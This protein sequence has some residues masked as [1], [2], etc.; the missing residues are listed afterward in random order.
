MA[1]CI[2]RIY[3]PFDSKHRP[4]D[5]KEHPGH[6]EIQVMGTLYIEKYDKNYTN[7]ILT[8][9]GNVTIYDNGNLQVSGNGLLC[10]FSFDATNFDSLASWINT[11]CKLPEQSK[12]TSADVYTVTDE[13]FKEYNKP[14]TNCFAWTA[15]MCSNMGYT[16]LQTIYQQYTYPNGSYDKDGYINY[17][18]WPMFAKY[19]RAWCF[20]GVYHS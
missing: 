8:Y 12:S 19:H 10:T 18:A 17:T 14:I 15:L 20:K 7:P 13:K 11:N 16:M 4:L 9:D 1:E 3:L 6:F 5:P 2:V